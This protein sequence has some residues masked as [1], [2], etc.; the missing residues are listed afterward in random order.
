MKK[1]ILPKEWYLDKTSDSNEMKIIF[2]WMQTQL[3]GDH[4]ELKYAS[5]Y[6]LFWKNRKNY[7]PNGT[8][9]MN[10]LKDCTLITFEQFHNHVV[11]GVEPY[12][13]PIENEDLSYLIPILKKH[14]I[15]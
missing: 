6:H 1:W 2:D 8:K 7:H 10:R 11:L 9:N 5:E 12:N 13:E 4:W 3:G 15:I 14:N